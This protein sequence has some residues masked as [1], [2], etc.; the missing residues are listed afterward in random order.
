MIPENY[1]I[2][3]NIFRIVKRYIIYPYVNNDIEYGLFED[4]V[5]SYHLEEKG[6]IQVSYT[7]DK[8]VQ[9]QI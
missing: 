6:P 1:F 5:E 4:L 8:A 2:F 9:T 3:T 7:W